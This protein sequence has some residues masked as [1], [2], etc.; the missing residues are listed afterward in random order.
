MLAEISVSVM[1]Y[2]YINIWNNCS[3]KQNQFCIGEKQGRDHRSAAVI[4]ILRLTQLNCKQISLNQNRLS[5]G[6]CGLPIHHQCTAILLR[7]LRAFALILR[8][9]GRTK[10]LAY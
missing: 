10:T 8:N 2:I 4:V 7:L 3:T 1:T 6:G 9:Q 5:G